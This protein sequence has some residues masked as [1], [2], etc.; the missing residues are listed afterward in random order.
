MY[1]EDKQRIRRITDDAAW[2]ITLCILCI[3]AGIVGLIS[4]FSAVLLFTPLVSVA[5]AAESE[6]VPA[7]DKPWSVSADLAFNT[8]YVWRGAA[9]TDE[10][11]LQPGLGLGYEGLTLSFWGPGAPTPTSC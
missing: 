11:V 7:E 2:G 10:P 4:I 5:S 6:P 3:I 8:K 9:P 1:E